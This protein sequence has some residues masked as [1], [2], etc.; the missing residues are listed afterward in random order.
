MTGLNPIAV[1]ILQQV[2]SSGNVTDDEDCEPSFLLVRP[3]AEVLEL[4][5]TINV[6][7]P[8]NTTQESMLPVV[9]VS[10]AFNRIL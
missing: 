8:A 10:P 4:G 5:L 1:E 6:F 2:I 3:C 7:T 9:F